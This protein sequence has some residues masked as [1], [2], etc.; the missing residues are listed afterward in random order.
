[1]TTYLRRALETTVRDVTKGFPVLLLTGP[2]QSGKTTLLRHLSEAER[3]YVSLDDPILRSLAKEDPRLF[4]DQYPPPVLIDEIQYAPSLLPYIKMVVDEQRRPGA[5]WLTGS[6]QFRMMKGITETLAGRVGILNLLGFS[7]REREKANLDVEP[8]LPTKNSMKDRAAVS[9]GNTQQVFQCI[10]DG[11]FPGLVAGQGVDREVFMSSYLQTYL[12]RDVRDLTQV[13]DLDSFARFLRACAARSGQLLNL[14]DLAR[15]VDVKVNTAKSW[16]SVLR[17]SF[18]IFLLRPYHS[19]LTKRLV[20]TPKLYFLDTG[21]MA[22]LTGWNSPEALASGAMAGTAFETHVVSEVVKSW[23]HRGREAPIYFYRD[24]DKREIDL[25]FEVDG[26]L[27]PVE[28]KR[29]ATVKRDWA[30]PFGALERLG[31]PVG[32]GAVVCLAPEPTVIDRSIQAVPV[33]WI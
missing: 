25:V 8:F 16:L 5:F 15:D 6:Q 33:G 1:M 20:K 2:R 17:A 3:S 22:H 10:W 7:Q 4:L 11:S 31:K 18:Q 28:I 23:W 14:T 21:L 19:N 32:E 29:A 13:G 30:R 24:K 9:R 12:E 26:R 27:H